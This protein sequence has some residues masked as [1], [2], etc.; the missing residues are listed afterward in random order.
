MHNSDYKK[1][2]TAEDLIRRYNL[3]NLKTDRKIIQTMRTT[4]V[5]QNTII[6]DFIS[7][8]SP[9][10]A[11]DIQVIWFY[12]GTPTTENEPFISLENKDDY[13]GDLYYDRETGKTYQLLKEED[14]YHWQELEDYELSKSL[15]LANG[16]ADIF[17]NK[18]NIFY[19]IP[20]TPYQIGDIWLDGTTIMR[21]RCARDAG[22]YNLADW[23]VQDD[24]SNDFVLNETRAVLDELRFTIE[25]NYVT[26]VQLETSRD[27]IL[28][29]V[30]AIT[31]EIITTATAKYEYYDEQLAKIEVSVGNISLD[32]T[33][34]QTSLGEKITDL[35]SKIDITAGEINQSIEDKIT[36]LETKITQTTTEITQSITDNVNDINSTIT[37]KV[38]SLTTEINKKVDNSTF[39]SKIQQ[40]ESSISSKVSK[41]DFGSYVQQYYDKFLVGF[42]NASRYIQ[43]DTS[44]IG[45]YN[46]SISSSSLLI[47]LNQ[48]GL[49]IYRDGRHV[50]N[51]TSSQY[52][53]DTSQK[54]LSF[55]LDA[56]GS[57]M[58]WFSKESSSESYY[59]SVLYYAKSG[60]FGRQNAGLYVTTN[61][62]GNGYNLS[63]FN[64][65]SATANEYETADNKSIPIITNIDVDE[66]GNLIWEKSAINVR[67]GLIT[68][69]PE[70]SENL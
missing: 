29:S 19:N 15:A 25:E 22:E 28:A 27:S 41:D 61:L 54:G 2:I 10:K 56:N 6:K 50:G 3:D 16:D 39:N 5:K 57:Y 64:M 20:I 8:I 11:D 55:Q 70:N 47:Q 51:I 7:N 48:S 38:D 32:V 30:D 59:S 26:K 69:V 67:S 68:S 17:D 13:L 43:M 35:E 1:A 42:N 58:G 44:G 40:T 18:R 34:V 33:N 21:C 53:S 4:I 46:G 37:Q 9:Y 62:Y 24:Y 63:G 65:A 23:V 66:E 36:G 49:G 31:T 45:I 52:N 60:K 12:S 14:N